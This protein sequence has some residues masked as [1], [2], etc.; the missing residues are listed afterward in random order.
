[1]ADFFNQYE[2][3]K[4]HE[5]LYDF[6]AHFKLTD[7]E[8]HNE[9]IKK[10]FPESDLKVLIEKC[11]AKLSAYATATPYPY[12][13][14]DRINFCVKYNIPIAGVIPSLEEAAQ[15]LRGNKLEEQLRVMKLLAQMGNRPKAIENDLI[16]LFD[17]RTLEDKEKLRNIQTLAVNVLGN[18]A[19][20]NARAINYMINSLTDYDNESYA[21]EEALV[22][23]GKPAV[24]PIIAKLDKTSDQDGGLQYRLITILGKIGKDAGPAVG[25]I[26]RVLKINRNKDV[27]YAA[28]AALQAIK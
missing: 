4:A 27:V 9:K 2:Y 22:K 11:R 20:A 24:A 13:R 17:K 1:M 14:E 3:E 18:S 19:T 26:Q 12:P 10:E 23:I 25:S 28:E 5:N 6:V 16:Q 21:A 15:I 8:D 7:Y